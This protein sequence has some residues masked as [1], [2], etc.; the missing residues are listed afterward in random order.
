LIAAIASETKGFPGLVPA[1][2]AAVAA[3]AAAV[4][5][6]LIFKSGIEAVAVV[7]SYV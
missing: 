5:F 3:E 2:K 4:A 6:L 7:E 1:S